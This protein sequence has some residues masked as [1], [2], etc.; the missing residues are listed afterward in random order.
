MNVT[1]T[2]GSIAC[3][4]RHRSMLLTRAPMEAAVLRL[5]TGRSVVVDDAF[6]AQ[7]AQGIVPEAKH[8]LASGRLQADAVHLSAEFRPMLVSKPSLWDSLR[9]TTL[10]GEGVQEPVLAHAVRSLAAV[11]SALSDAE[12]RSDLSLSPAWPAQGSGPR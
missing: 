11:A 3:G 10:I 8:L 2:L 1:L 4:M 9:F 12:Q 6:G 7:T 5:R